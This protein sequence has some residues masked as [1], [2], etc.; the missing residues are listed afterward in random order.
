MKRMPRTLGAAAPKPSAGR[1]VIAIMDGVVAS[2]EAV[3]KGHAWQPSSERIVYWAG[4]KLDE[5]WLVTTVIRPNA[6]LR[7][8]SFRTSA[9]DNAKVVAYLA[10]AGLSLVGQVHTHP[11][12]F[13]DHSQGDDRDAFMPVENSLSLVVPFY[14]RRGMLPLTSCGVH[15]Y[16]SGGYRRLTDAEIDSTFC[17]IC[18]MADLAG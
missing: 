11:G 4:V 18:S 8:G 3:L 2:S 15:R 14:G 7:R 5:M 12:A 13:V 9:T 10:Q 6:V 1:P 16:E 17:T